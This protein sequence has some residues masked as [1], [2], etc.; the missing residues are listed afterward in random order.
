VEISLIP[1]RAYKN[2]GLVSPAF[3]WHKA[4]TFDRDTSTEPLLY[5]KIAVHVFATINLPDIPRSHN[6]AVS[7]VLSSRPANEET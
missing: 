1:C 6:E 4:R 7:S 2:S 5:C 3:I